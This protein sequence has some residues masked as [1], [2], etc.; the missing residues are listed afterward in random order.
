M[1]KTA[2]AALL[3]F[4]SFVLHS[5][6]ATAQTELGL[7]GGFSIYSGDLS[8]QEFGVYFNDMRPAFGAFARFGLGRAAAIRLGVNIGSLSADDNNTG[9]EDRGLAFRTRLTE[10]SLIGEVNLFKLGAAPNRGLVPYLFGG[11][12]VFN[13]NPE[14]PFDGDYVELQPLGTEGQGLPNYEAPYRLT[15]VAIPFGIGVKILLNEQVS[16]GLEFGGRK[17][18]TDHLD[19]V[20][21]ASVN[22]FDILDGNGELAAQLSRPTVE[23]PSPDLNYSRGGEFND[24]YYIGGL[25][26]AF[27]LNGS[28]RR[29]G[30]NSGRGMGCPTF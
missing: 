17:L 1:R 25:S 14:A 20:S 6:S 23:D 19:D 9:R 12:A 18:F 16:L 28:G 10:F 24:W 13:F 5:P 2:F 26:I 22:Y 27:K 21:A 8:P 7:M 4:S 30:L 15:Q 11:A 3:F 29:G